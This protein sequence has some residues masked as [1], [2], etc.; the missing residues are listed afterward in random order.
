MTMSSRVALMMDGEIV[1]VATP[2]EIYSNPAD[3]RVARFIGSPEINLLQARADLQGHI[4][5]A[6]RATTLRAAASGPLTVGLRPEILTIDDGTSDIVIDGRLQRVERLGHDVL[7]H[8]RHDSSDKNATLPV[9]A[10]LFEAM[11][12]SGRLGDNF[13]IGARASSALLFDADGKR[14]AALNV[15]LAAPEY[16]SSYTSGRKLLSA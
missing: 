1:Q 11:Q 15:A 6:G 16:V 12:T 8:V 5:I 4:S 14:L 10:A 7:L 3:V 2:H 13:K 9:S